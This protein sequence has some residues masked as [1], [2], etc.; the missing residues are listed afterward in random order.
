MWRSLIHLSFLC[1]AILGSQTSAQAEEPIRVQIMADPVSLDPALAYDY[2]SFMIN[3]VL[4]HGLFVIDGEGELQNGLAKSYQ[5][6]KKNTQYRFKLRPD[7]FWSDGKQVTIEDF[8]F[9]LRRTLDPKTGAPDAKLLHSIRGARNFTLGKGK[10]SDVAIYKSGDELVIELEHPDAQFLSSLT[11]PQTVPLRQEFYD[12]SAGVWQDSFP[13]TGYYRIQSHRSNDEIVLEPNPMH[14]VPGQRTIIYKVVQDENA[15]I[16]L[17]ETGRLDIVTSVLPLTSIQRYREKGWLRTSP[18]ARVNYIAFNANLEPF[19]R[20]E[21]RRAFAGVISRKVISDLME[22]TVAPTRSLVPPG[23]P[24]FI[25]YQ[26]GAPLSPKILA[27]ME[28]IRKWEKKPPV[29]ISYAVAG[30]NTILMEQIQDEMKRKLDLTVTLS[31]REFKSFLAEIKT[32]S[33]QIRYLGMGAGYRDA[34]T[35][36]GMFSEEFS[37]NTSHYANPVYKE[38]VHE[39]SILPDGPT[40]NQKIL[41]AQHLLID[42][43]AIVLPIFHRLQT[44]AV[45]SAIRGFQVNEYSV[46]QLQKLQK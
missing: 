17:F 6:R 39:I 15:A 27:D 3:G 37:P 19:N 14:H 22:G 41:E 36:L 24:G 16:H 40:R 46:I 2:Y 38:L 23:C 11:H 13:T 10:A 12:K 43:D 7:A 21:W 31:P 34:L 5:V 1:L 32:N 44:F 45:S 9:G 30:S 29:T 26:E 18:S 28:T 42:E 20:P 25:P 33:P 35:L 8:I 4:M